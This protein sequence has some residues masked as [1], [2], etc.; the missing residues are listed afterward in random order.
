VRRVGKHA[1]GAIC[2][3]ISPLH[4]V[5]KFVD[6][7]EALR[8]MKCDSICI[9]DMAGLLR[10]QVAYDLVRGIK[11]R[12][13]QDTLV[14][15]HSHATTGITLVSLM[16]AI[17]AGAD[18]VDASISSL[19]LGTGHNPTES[20]MEMLEGTPYSTRLDRGKL[21]RIRAHF[22]EI[23]PRYADLEK[24]QFGV[25][26]EILATQMTG[27]MRSD[28]IDQL[29]QQNAEHRLKEVL[30]EVPHIRKDAGYPPLV[31]PCSQI[32]GTQAVLNILMGRYKVMTGEFADLMLGYYGETPGPRDLAVTEAAAK[33]A[34]KELFEGRPADLLHPEW[35]DLRTQAFAL[36]GCNGS[37]EDVLTYAMFPQDARKFF[38][39]RGEGP[40]NPNRQEVPPAPT[41]AA[42]SPVPP[43]DSRGPVQSTVTYCVKVGGKS[44]QVTVQPV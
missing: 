15:V 42:A 31:T 43:V 9:K 14:H 8:E 37:D 35:D 4:T 36:Q 44:H 29:Q 41:A 11:R 17:E 25:D 26:T 21:R 7:A 32:L 33:H 16:K 18:I 20:V 10:P 40:R 6:L 13:G 5:E 2:Y 23:R 38:V 34:G 19:S 22:A 27:S 28:I 24:T 3:T 30:A 39:R 12:C 1:E